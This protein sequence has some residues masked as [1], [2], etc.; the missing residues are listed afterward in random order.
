[1]HHKIST[2]RLMFIRILN[3]I[4]ICMS[5]VIILGWLLNYYE[6][7]TLFSESPTMKLNTAI[8]LVLTG[9]CIVFPW[10]KN[11]L[12]YNLI[13]V[14]IF[15]IGFITIIEYIWEPSFSI[16]TLIADDKYSSQF[17]GRMALG[18]AICFV[19]I[20]ISLWLVNV[21]LARF[22]VMAFY[23]L[24]GTSVIAI[25]SI[26]TF[27]L[28][29]PVGRR[30]F[31]VETMSVSTSILFLLISFAV[32]LS[33]GSFGLARGYM[34]DLAG[35]RLMKFLFPFV[36][37]V[38]VF[39]SYSI[40]RNVR[41]GVI[42]FEFG[43]IIGTVFF[44]L[45]SIIFISFLGSSLNKID[46][47]R[48]KL[49]ESL[50][51]TNQEL[52]Q[53]KYGL[54]Q[55]S[56]L[57]ITD[58]KG[59]ITFAN[60]KFCEISKYSREEL[61]GQSH[62]LAYSGYHSKDF[63]RKLCKKINL[64]EVWMGGVKNRASDGSFYWVHAVIIPF[65]NK[66]GAIYQYLAIGQD[67]TKHKDISDQ[68]ENLKLKSQEIEQ[69]SYIASHDLQEPLNSMK[70]VI[71]FLNEDY[72]EK[73]D[74]DGKQYLSFLS[75]AASKMEDLVNGLLAY[76]RL[77]R[78]KVLSLVNFNK[79]VAELIDDLTY[80]I[81]QSH[82]RMT[83]EKLPEINAYEAEI[84]LIFMNLI[85]NSSKFTRPGVVPQI[86]IGAIEREEEWEFYVKDNG[87]GISEENSQKV[88][89]FFTRLNNRT[90]FEGIGIGLAHCEK[91]AR[92]H[93]GAIWFK[94]ELGSGT[95]FYFT[96]NKNLS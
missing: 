1:M 85:S 5:I 35:R 94:S 2:N 11:G 78:N 30:V 45:L 20:G 41:N 82:A 79:I 28:Q 39:I 53:F 73:L 16:D 71:N 66:F 60:D 42:D 84:K 70:A 22:R 52:V 64:G 27:I 58:A 92:L 90:D 6:I 15:L 68:Y 61:L 80:V 24:A 9:L 48:K 50:K 75:Q 77:G 62:N 3:A 83:I 23:T 36:I 29:R 63:Y 34:Q 25:L 57:A 88:F 56:M 55:S 31:L 69:F 59:I 76:S 19:F 65:K 8:G 47:K 91:I 17:P 40:I 13:V 18:T 67:I 46:F 86:E 51:A 87:I 4:V 21:R 93:R 74:K 10:K 38:P 32:F 72:E 81:G 14:V 89:S 96:V 33:N 37:I 44:V 49:E 7:V 26:I 43:L 54:D 12:P 95:T